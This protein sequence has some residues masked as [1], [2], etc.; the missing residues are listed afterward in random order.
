MSIFYEVPIT[1]FILVKRIIS[2]KGLRLDES[3]KLVYKEEFLT[4]LDSMRREKQ[5]KG[6]TRTKLELL[7]KL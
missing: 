4:R 3:F 2:R 7:K 5:L 1:A 6:W